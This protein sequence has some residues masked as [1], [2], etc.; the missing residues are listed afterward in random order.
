M[1][2][3]SPILILVFFIFTFISVTSG[4]TN[5][6]EVNIPIVLL[7]DFGSEDYRV[8]QLKGIIYS[9]NP[10]A[11]LADGSH[12]VPAFDIPTG[13]F[14]LDIAAREFPENVVFVGVIAPY[15]QTETKY[16][17]LTTEKNQLF[18]LPDNGLL[19]YVIKDMSIKTIYQITNQKLFDKPIRELA[20]ERIE[21]KIGALLA[22]GYHPQDVGTPLTNPMTLD[23]QEPAII[24]RK[25][26]G[27]VVYIDHFGN[28]VTN[29]S[30]KTASEFG[31]KP[32]DLVQVKS[33][34]S[35]ISA[36]YGTIYS[37]V[38]QGEEI[39]FVNNNL[40]VVQLS[41][42]LDNF[43]DKYGVKAG[44]KIEIEK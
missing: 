8:P 21:G 37:D 17:V 19:T 12:S 40:G 18:V 23:V 38:P 24:D 5:Q 43:A 31:V 7:T 4:C 13:A 42:N 14:I 41:I 6:K 44:T 34:Q 20:A 28:S 35:V 39:V 29:I 10:Q 25:L 36:K 27:T 11:K 3:I 1:K 32:G 16:L 2:K 9:N 33:Q 22:A 26:M 30:D 15:S